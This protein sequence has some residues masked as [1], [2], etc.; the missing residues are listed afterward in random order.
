MYREFVE[1]DHKE[2]RQFVD[3]VGREVDLVVN[4]HYDT[5]DSDSVRHY[6]NKCGCEGPW[7]MIDGNVS[8]NNIQTVAVELRN[9][10]DSVKL[11]L[12]SESVRTLPQTY[13]GTY[14]MTKRII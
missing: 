9:P 7:V 1:G 14:A 4:P 2:F 8:F 6:L 5:Y 12:L 13:L 11:K 3:F 10:E